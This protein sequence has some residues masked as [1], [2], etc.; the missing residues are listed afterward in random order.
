MLTLSDYAKQHGIKY[1]AAW[2][3]YKRD[4]IP[5]ATKNEFGKILIP[6]DS[7]GRPEKTAV[8][9]R[10]SSSQNKDNL[11]G[12]ALRLTQF[13]NARGWSVDVVVK[14]VGSGLN[15]RRPKLL[16]LLGDT[17]VTRIVVEH[18]DRLTR[19]GYAYIELLALRNKV[20][21]VVVNNVDGDKQD[22][23]QDFVSLVTSFCARL[24]GLR[25]TRRK[26]E[27]LIRELQHD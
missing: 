7:P 1:R 19:F 14:E 18:K 6:E 12:Q 22:L 4:L 11:E 24:Y 3:R 26:T 21:L 17:S 27:Q 5:R 16:K 2:N 10:V 9:A 25:R 20:E 8:Y 23:M 15:D 13:A